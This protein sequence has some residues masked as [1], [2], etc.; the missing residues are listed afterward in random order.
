MKNYRKKP[1]VIQAMQLRWDNW[2]EMCEFAGVGLLSEGKPQGCYITPAG[3][4]TNNPTD[5]I[6]LLIPTLEGIMKAVQG[7]YIIRGVRGEL[8]SCKQ[9]IFEET[10]EEV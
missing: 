6:G 9:D 10:Y 3:A 4:D 2:S 8:Y 1:V 7:D 5:T